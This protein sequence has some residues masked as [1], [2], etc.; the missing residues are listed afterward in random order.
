MERTEVVVIGG[1][2]TGTGI[3]RDLALRG[4]SAV[5]LEKE[6][7]A[8]GATGRCHGLLHSGARYAVKDVEAAKECIAENRILKKI[9]AHCIEDTGGMFV[10]LEED[11]PEYVK[12]FVS[13]CQQAGIVI[14]E[15]SPKEVRE[16]EPNVTTGITKAYT[17]PD[18]YIDV[19]QLTAANAQ[20]AIRLGAKVKT[21]SQM[22][23]VD[24]KNKMVQ[25]VHYTDTLTGENKYI[26]CEVLIN[27]A[28]PWAG[29][30]AEQLGVEVNIVCNRGSLVIFNQRLTNSVVNRLKVPGDCDLIVPGGPVSILGTTSIN[31]DHPE[32]LEL[33]PGEI[34]YMLGLA[35]VTFPGLKEARIIRT[36]S[37]VRPLYSPKSSAGTSGGR[38]ISRN[39][40]LLDH[41]VEDGIEG[42]VSIL[43]GKLTTYRLMAEV[44]VD[45]VCRKL[46]V[47]KE[48]ST[49]QL[50]LKPEAA[51]SSLLED[52]RILSAP[53]F[54][55]ARSRLG[56]DLPL[57]L[58]RIKKD[59]LQAEILCECEYVTRAEL[60]LALEGVITVP[61]RTISDLA[62]RTRMG[63]GTCQGS[64][65]GY[66][67][68]LVAYEKGIWKGTESKAELDKFLE[69]RWKGQS[70]APY[71]KQN[72][73]MD[74]SRYLYDETLG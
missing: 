6:D 47:S 23:K 66:K 58:E 52:R 59:P 45:L 41:K 46:S 1:G 7:L 25:G 17:V 56:S 10:H 38:E 15:L 11:D 57:L 18:G 72:Q 13:G 35:A 16:R 34:D 26:A 55:K 37:G 36:F 20:D 62:R 4:I 9:A 42:F 64:F 27:A 67:A 69:K 33:K 31:V 21:Y 74:L 44:T 48:C 39:Y 60:E 28:G 32:N 40:V 5:L 54:E 12:K 2:C 29:I 43:G 49:A 22:T 3:L 61:S 51:N 65:C 63:L 73:Q 8:C 70:L 24:V 19:F 53:V 30:V 50:P 14:E 68:M 71:G